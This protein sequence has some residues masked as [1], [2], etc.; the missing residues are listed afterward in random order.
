MYIYRY[1]YT[2]IY[3]YTHM[4]IFKNT[5]DHLTFSQMLIFHV[6][7][8]FVHQKSSFLRQTAIAPEYL[9]NKCQTMSEYGPEYSVKIWKKGYIA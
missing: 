1:V 8:R 5:V 2:Y 6:Q 4:Y 3:I 9:P 7:T